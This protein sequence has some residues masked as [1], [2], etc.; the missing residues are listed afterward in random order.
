M[1]ARYP[2]FTSQQR[3]DL[4]MLIARGEPLVGIGIKVD[5]LDLSRKWRAAHPS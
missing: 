4:R 5:M 3:A 2:Q 1:P